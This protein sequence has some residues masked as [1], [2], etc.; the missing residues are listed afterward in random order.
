[1]YSETKPGKIRGVMGYSA[2]RFA[3][4]LWR[5]HSTKITVRRLYA[6]EQKVIR[7]TDQERNAIADALGLPTYEVFA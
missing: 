5:E 1:M 3:E 7:G 2:P 4:L 6:I